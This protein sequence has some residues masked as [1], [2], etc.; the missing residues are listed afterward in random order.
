MTIDDMPLL[1]GV[2]GREREVD[3]ARE[4]LTEADCP[5]IFVDG[6]LAGYA[7]L[8]CQVRQISLVIAGPR[9]G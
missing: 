8:S 7:S 6:K 2:P 9:S 5:G 4:R 1:A 3:K